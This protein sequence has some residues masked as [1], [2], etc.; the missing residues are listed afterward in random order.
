MLCVPLSQAK[1]TL[2]PLV[3]ILNKLPRSLSLKGSILLNQAQVL[4]PKVRF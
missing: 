3:D 1:V 2:K 4:S